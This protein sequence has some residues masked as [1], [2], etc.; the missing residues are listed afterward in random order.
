MHEAFEALDRFRLLLLFAAPLL[1]VA[2]S[3]GGYWLSTR[4]L[5][6]VDEISRAAQRI[7]IE[8]LA[9]RLPV[10]QTGDQLQRLSETLN[11]MFSRL[12]AAVRRITQFTADAS[13]ELRAPVSLI[14]TTA[15]VAVQKEDRTAQEYFQALQE[16]VSE[17]ERTSQV[18]DSLM[19]LARADSGTETLEC[20]DIDACTIVREA[21]AQGEKLARN[22]DLGFTLSLPNTRVPVEADSSALRRALLILIDNA[23]KYTPRGGLVTVELNTSTGFAIV[24]VSDTGI[25]IAREE[26]PHIFDR[27]WR[28]DKT[29]SREE[30]GAGL[31]LSIAKWIVETHRGSIAVE[32]E[33]GKGSTFRVRVP[34]D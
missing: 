25:G 13:H 31:G 16:I 27:F 26:V 3:A 5:S 2:A 34:L 29:R 7:S 6:P 19:L 12:D 28:A 10:S 4:A 20:A 24:S 11:A 21:A 33:P 22:H 18:V 14:R 30:G 23:V 1:L 9:D 8:N 32:S 17:S 15:E